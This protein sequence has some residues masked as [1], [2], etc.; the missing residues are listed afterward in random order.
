MEENQR[1]IF[2]RKSQIEKD[3]RNSNE[4]FLRTS[5][6][7]VD[8]W[9][10]SSI[11]QIRSA[12]QRARTELE[13]VFQRTKNRFESRLEQISN[14]FSSKTELFLDQI[15]QIHRQISQTF[16]KDLIQN[17]STSI[18][19]IKIFDQE[20]CSPIER[21]QTNSNQSIQFSD[22]CRTATCSKKQWNGTTI[23]GHF[24]YSAGV[25]R[26]RFRINKQG[27]NQFF[28]GITSAA[29]ETNPWK[30]GTPL[31]FGW[32][33]LPFEKVKNEY[34]ENG[35]VRNGDELTLT[36]DCDHRTLRLEHHPTSFIVEESVSYE[37]CPLPWKIAIV[38]Y[39]PGDSLS[40][41]P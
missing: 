23:S 2:D 11:E 19:M 40:I 7:R 3:F 16:N 6:L 33:Q 37:R 26:I 4:E 34:Q 25:H 21:F 18:S 17:D 38:L 20:N 13:E 15:Q 32:W 35:R 41:L 31:A 29:R 30:T 27:K 1:E 28:F 8:Q 5:L 24:I 12:A 22:Q 14:K 36:L 9:E 10:Q 39:A